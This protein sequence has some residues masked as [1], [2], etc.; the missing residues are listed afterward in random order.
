[1]DR[2]QPLN[3]TLSGDLKKTITPGAYVKVTVEVASKPLIT[4]TAGLC[5]QTAEADLACPIEAGKV[6]FTKS[7]NLPSVIPDVRISIISLS[8]V[9]H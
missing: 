7:F 6:A 1:M 9:W 4:T 5:D 2:G 3:L 8:L